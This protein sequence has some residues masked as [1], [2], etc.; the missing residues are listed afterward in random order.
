MTIKIDF[1]FKKG[2]YVE[3]AGMSEEQI[4][5]LEYQ[6]LSQSGNLELYNEN[7]WSEAKGLVWDIEGDV[8]YVRKP[9]VI[10]TL[11][12]NLLT[13]KDIFPV[14]EQ[15][16]DTDM[17]GCK[18][19]LEELGYQ[20]VTVKVENKGDAIYEGVASFPSGSTIK[21]NE[22]EPMKGM[23]HDVQYNELPFDLQDPATWHC[24]KEVAEVLGEVDA[25]YELGKVL[26]QINEGE[27]TTNAWG[28]PDELDLENDDLDSSFNWE[29]TVQGH[30]FWE[31]IS[32]G[33][34]PEGYDSTPD[35]PP[36]PEVD[37]K[38]LS[39]LSEVPEDP[40]RAVLYPPET[41][42]EIIKPS[43]KIPESVLGDIKETFTEG[44]LEVRSQTIGELVEA[45]QANIPEHVGIHFQPDGEV[46][47]ECDN[48]Y[49]VVSEL[50]AKEI[51]SAIEFVA[52]YGHLVIGKNVE[53]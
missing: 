44:S 33:T 50:T 5:S 1:E 14:S 21:L 35:T 46:L 51:D 6:M 30:D 31:F 24:F 53:E 45:I 32:E 16:F 48:A 29:E 23:I 36:T 42:E 3:L 34:K 17:E 38:S 10:Q 25:E 12:N 19:T 11:T 47:L 37:K 20:T 18:T 4:E 2:D 22:G 43:L 52:H 39:G 40:Y 28:Y 27:I 8:Y 41:L 13:I 7:H 49:V 26:R 9:Y 15:E